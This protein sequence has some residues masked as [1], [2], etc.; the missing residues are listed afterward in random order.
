MAL[1]TLTAAM[2]RVVYGDNLKSGKHVVMIPPAQRPVE[3]IHIALGSILLSALRRWNKHA[4]LVAAGLANAKI[5]EVLPALIAYGARIY[6]VE[7][8]DASWELTRDNYIPILTEAENWQDSLL[9]LLATK[10]E[11]SVLVHVPSLPSE[12]KQEDDDDNM[13]QEI[14]V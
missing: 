9:H 4:T 5:P 12:K 2:C 11:Y 14:I 6:V 1:R 10:T 3:S 7:S 8:G 13:S